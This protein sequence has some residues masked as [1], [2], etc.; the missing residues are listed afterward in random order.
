M[1]LVEGMLLN[2]L[3][4][5]LILLTIFVQATEERF[6]PLRRG[7]YSGVG[8]SM[9]GQTRLKV[10]NPKAFYSIIC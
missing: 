10:V 2:E 8:V 4:E 1:S 3:L 9:A 6:Q 5:L 7:S